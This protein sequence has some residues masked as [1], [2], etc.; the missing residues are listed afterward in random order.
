[1]CAVDIQAGAGEITSDI[2]TSVKIALGKLDEAGVVYGRCE[3]ARRHSGS[4]RS[5]PIGRTQLTPE[6]ESCG[7]RS[8]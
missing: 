3:V 8:S 4:A 5:R 7:V 1:M 6:E 2:P